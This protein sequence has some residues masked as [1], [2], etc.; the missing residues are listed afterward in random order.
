MKS[1]RGFHL[2]DHRGVGEGIQVRE[3]VEIRAVCLP[4][5]EERV[6]LDRV[7]H[8]RCGS[9]RDI[10]VHRSHVLRQDRARRTVLR[11]DVLEHRGVS[12]LLGM[13]IDHQV[14][15]RQQPREVVWLHVDERDPI[16]AFH[17]RCRQYLDLQVQQLQHA[18]VLGAGHAVHAPDDGGLSGAAQDVAQRKPAG[19]GIR[20]RI[21]VQQDEDAIRIRHI[22]LILLHAL[23]IDRA[24]ELDLQRRTREFRQREAVHFGEARFESVRTLRIFRRRAEYPNER[25]AGGANGLDDFSEGTAAVVFNDDAGGGSEVGADVGIDTLR[26]AYAEAEAFAVEAPPQG[27]AFHKDVQ[28]VA[29]GDDR[30]EQPHHQLGMTDR[31]TPHQA[32]L[33]RPVA[34]VFITDDSRL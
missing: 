20:I 19:D 23:P 17:L 30:V 22:A 12:R 4:I 25:A 21:V 1:S 32:G 33:S 9:L 6:R 8:R 3:G 7:E 26:I 2:A 28:L 27:G 10:E 29:G 11:A 14:D 24:S 34:G 13:M 31:E 18:Q 16:E 5:E 15:L